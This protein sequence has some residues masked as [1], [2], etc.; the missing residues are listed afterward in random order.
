MRGFSALWGLQRLVLP[1]SSDCVSAPALRAKTHLVPS[2]AGQGEHRAAGLPV[3]NR[4]RA[5]AGGSQA[6]PDAVW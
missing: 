6:E 5:C 1:S 4:Q 3:P 2:S